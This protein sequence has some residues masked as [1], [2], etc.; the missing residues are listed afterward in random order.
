MALIVRRRC[1][2]GTLA[3]GRIASIKGSSTAHCASVNI[4]PTKKQ[5]NATARKEFRR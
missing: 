2:G 1:R 4:Q 5:D 3:G